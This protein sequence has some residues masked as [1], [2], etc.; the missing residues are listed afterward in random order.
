[1]C[2]KSWLE[3]GPVPSAFSGG[4][5][6]CP[7]LQGAGNYN[8]WWH[9]DNDGNCFR[10]TAWGTEVALVSWWCI[11]K[12]W[13]FMAL[14]L[15]LVRLVC[16]NKSANQHSVPGKGDILQLILKEVGCWLLN[17][18]CGLWLVG[19]STAI[20]CKDWVTNCILSGFQT[21]VMKELHLLLLAWHSISY[22]WLH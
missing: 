21:L 4:L 9:T 3:V 6:V 1:M 13:R 10:V 15:V 18:C 5:T 17:H 16:C 11:S 7:D 12:F 20:P 2:F 19:W 14:D 8:T 22:V